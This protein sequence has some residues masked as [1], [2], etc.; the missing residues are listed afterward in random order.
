L[1]GSDVAIREEGELRSAYTASLNRLGRHLFLDLQADPTRDTER[2]FEYHV[3]Y[4][5]TLSRVEFVRDTL[6]LFMLHPRPDSAH[7]ASGDTLEYL[8]D[9]RSSDDYLITASTDRL[10]EFL[11]R[12]SD[13]RF[14]FMQPVAFLR[15]H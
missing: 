11:R 6:K 1:T 13:D 9:Y 5:H 2:K 8:T 10:R 4:G 12:H 15:H 3:I 14:W 7:V